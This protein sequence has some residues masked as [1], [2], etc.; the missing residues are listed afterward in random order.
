VFLSKEVLP[1]FVSSAP[2]VGGTA[3]EG[4]QHLFTEK[5]KST[6]FIREIWAA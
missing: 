5:H 6:K 2:Y 4:W 3:N 1:A